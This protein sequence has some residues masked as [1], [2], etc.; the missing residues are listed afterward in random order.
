[1]IEID[2]ELGVAKPTAGAVLLATARIDLKR[3]AWS[4]PERL[5]GE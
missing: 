5:R 4:W 1:L 2:A 3:H